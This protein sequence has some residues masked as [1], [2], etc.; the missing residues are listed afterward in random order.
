[1]NL[2]V[3]SIGFPAEALDVALVLLR[4]AGL[5][6]IELAPFN[7]FGRWDVPDAALKEMRVRL[8][9]AGLACVA[10]QG[11]LHQAPAARLFTAPEAL[12]AQLRQVARIAGRLGAAACVFGAPRQR[13]PGDLP[14]GRAWSEAVRFFRG[15]A[16]VFAAEGTALAFEANAAGYGCR[17]VTTTAEAIRLVRE[18]DTPGFGLQIDTGTV[19][20]EAEP[21]DVLAAAAPLA[22]H[23]HVS[24]PGLAPVGSAGQDHAPLAAALRAGGYAGSLSIEMQA[25]AD[26]PGDIAAAIRF[27]RA[28][29]L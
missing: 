5:G 8:A 10:L 12:A 25:T 13:D 16:P 26:W 29:Y 27:V 22:V 17:F 2:A 3:S 9:A 4:D 11:I 20:T 18:V 1:M 23:A 15:I 28:H 24:E 19:L 7:H 14:P 6:A 21:P